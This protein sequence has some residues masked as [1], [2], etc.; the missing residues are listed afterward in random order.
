MGFNAGLSEPS[1]AASWPTDDSHVRKVIREFNERGLSSLDP[2][3]R[4]A[5]AAIRTTRALPL[6][7][8]RGATVGGGF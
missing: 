7:R 3:Y 6:T 4:A 8:S 2:D 5:G 1:I